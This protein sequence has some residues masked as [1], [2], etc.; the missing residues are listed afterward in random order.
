MIGEIAQVN[1]FDEL[2]LSK[3]YTNPRKIGNQTIVDAESGYFDNRN[4]CHCGNMILD[5]SKR[6]MNE[7]MCTA[8]DIGCKIYYQ[9]TDSMHISIEDV[10]KLEKEYKSK[11]GRDLIGKKLGQFHSDFESNKGE[12]LGAVGH[13]CCAKK[14]YVDKLI[15]MQF[16]V[17]SASDDIANA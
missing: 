16:N 4:A 13:V 10:M 3:K 6:I 15:V 11:Y 17:V 7:V 1:I 12:V 14:M 9:D 8:E 5:M 2:E